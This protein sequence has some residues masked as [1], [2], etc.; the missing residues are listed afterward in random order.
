MLRAIRGPEGADSRDS[1]TLMLG[2]SHAVLAKGSDSSSTSDSDSSDS[3]DSGRGGGS[4]QWQQQQWQQQQWQ[5]QQWQQ[6]QAMLQQQQQ[7]QARPALSNETLMA[8]MVASDAHAKLRA[9]QETKDASLSAYGAVQNALLSADILCK[10][11]DFDGRGN[12]GG[13]AGLQGY[14]AM[15]P[16][17]GQALNPLMGQALNPLMGQANLGVAQP[18]SKAPAASPWAQMATSPFIQGGMG[19]NA[20]QA[21]QVFAPSQFVQPGWVLAPTGAPAGVSADPYNAWLRS[22]I[23]KNYL[24]ELGKQNLNNQLSIPVASAQGR[25]NTWGSMLPGMIG[26]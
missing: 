8:M 23:I 20:Q 18:L 26:A 13:L 19:G 24:F 17:M 6:Q 9:S 14:Q 15:N 5:Q 4:P 10:L 7:Q 25:V 12:A 1:K 16:L 2:L 3:S 21:G 22:F 11:M